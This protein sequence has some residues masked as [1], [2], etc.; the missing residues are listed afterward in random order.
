MLTDPVFYLC[1]VPAVILVGLAKG[2]FTGLGALGMPLMALGIDPVAGAA[3]MRPILI[4][5]DVVGVAAFRKS[6]SASLLAT[7]LPGAF[8][9]IA[10]AY[11]FA[12]RVPSQGVLAV[13]GLIAIAFGALRLWAEHR[14]RVAAPSDAPAWMGSLFGLLAGF[15]S[16]IAHAGGPPFQIWAMRRGLSRDDFVGTSAIFFA[17][18]NWAKVPVFAALG[19]FT[20]TNL[21]TAAALLPVAVLSSLAGVW[22]VRKVPV[23]RLYRI[24]Y[25]LMIVTGP[26]LLLDAAG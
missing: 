9:G 11:L 18:V 1:A 24:I 25:A 12:A 6:W 19:E 22:L 21:L 17:V 2:G 14:G 3:I 23:E 5:Q 16:Q 4:V 15:T 20:R 10:L 7:M 8:L 13:L 26:K